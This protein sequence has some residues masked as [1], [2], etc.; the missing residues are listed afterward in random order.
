MRL[1]PRLAGTLLAL[2]AA[3]G[4][5]TCST[6]G[7]LPLESSGEPGL[8]LGSTKYD[9]DGV[10][11]TG[12][13]L[14]PRLLDGWP[15]MG[16][17]HWESGRLSSFDLAEPFTPPGWPARRILPRGTRV[18]LE[19]SGAEPRGVRFVFFPKDQVIDGIPVDGGPGKI[20]CHFWPDG[21]LR[22]VFLSKDAEVA[23]LPVESSH[24]QPLRF[25]TNGQVQ[26][27][28]VSRDVEL[29]GRLVSAGQV[30]EFDEAGRL[31]A[32]D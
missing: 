13:L 2:L 15:A 25:H 30:V 32:V 5:Y 4:L 1:S 28:S 3:L 26:S 22:T 8:A 18:T 12:R 20:M 29:E 9:D 31:L 24:F 21:G 16:W 14:E 10:L 27:C 6:C 23:G 7:L 11:A 17:V 19:Q